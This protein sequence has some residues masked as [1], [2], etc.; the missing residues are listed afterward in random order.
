MHTSTG[1]QLTPLPASRP[2]SRTERMYFL[3]MPT[4]ETLDL[5]SI[6]TSADR[7]L[8]ALIIEESVLYNNEFR[9]ALPMEFSSVYAEVIFTQ[10]EYTCS[11]FPN[12]SA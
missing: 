10:P 3:A 2:S 4:A 9:R 12:V 8:L 5:Q 7:K 1:I 11:F 6:I